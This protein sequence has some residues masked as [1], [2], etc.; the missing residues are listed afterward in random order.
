MTVGS[1]P[2][3]LAMKLRASRPGRDGDDIAALVRAC[4]VQSVAELFVVAP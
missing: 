3:L 2:L 4:G 1:A